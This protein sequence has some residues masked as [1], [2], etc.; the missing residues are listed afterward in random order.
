MPQ[1]GAADI[2]NRR[3]FFDWA[4]FASRALYLKN[5]LVTCNAVSQMYGLNDMTNWE[6]S[7]S[8]SSGSEWPAGSLLVGRSGMW[9]TGSACIV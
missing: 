9:V 5:R 2:S 1:E 7:R 8:L 3:L 6:N 4:P